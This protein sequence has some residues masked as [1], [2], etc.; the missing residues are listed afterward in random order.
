LLVSVQTRRMAA[1]GAIVGA[2]FAP[3]VAQQGLTSAFSAAQMLAKNVAV[4]AVSM[5]V[6][7][8][9]SIALDAER[10]TLLDVY[11]AV[12]LKSNIG[13]HTPNPECPMGAIIAEPLQAVLDETEAAVNLVLSGN[14]IAKVSAETVERII[15]RRKK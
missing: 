10:I 9:C 15:A 3:T 12:K 14:T 2:A 7:D 1:T 13:V 8:R 4:M 5:S 11:R 6:V